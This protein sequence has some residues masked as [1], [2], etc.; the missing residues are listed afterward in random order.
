MTERGRE[1]QKLA[2]DRAVAVD[3]RYRDDA[4]APGVAEQLTVPGDGGD[5]DLVLGVT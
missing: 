5:H 3:R 4:D 1:E 2:G